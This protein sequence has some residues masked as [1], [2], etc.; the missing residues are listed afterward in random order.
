M[1]YNEDMTT[2]RKIRGAAVSLVAA[3]EAADEADP[4]DSR[5]AKIS[6][7]LN[8]VDSALSAFGWE[9]EKSTPTTEGRTDPRD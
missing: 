9:N 3:F 6:A 8:A 5:K 7:A 2:V 1:I 4:D